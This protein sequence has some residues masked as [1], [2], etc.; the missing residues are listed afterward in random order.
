M[1]RFKTGLALIVA[2]TMLTACGTRYNGPSS[3]IL[4]ETEENTV[5]S[6][7]SNA[8]ANI[9]VEDDS[10]PPHEGMTRSLLTNEWVDDS[11]ADT[12]PIAVMIP[13]EKDAIP[14]YNLSKAS[15][16]YEANVEGRMTRLMA[17]YE[18]WAA[19]G[20]IGNVRSLRSYYAYWAF[21]W[22]AFLVH[23]GGPFFINE[24]IDQPTT[25]N[26][27]G[28][29][30]SDSAAFY[31]STDRK[32]PHNTYITGSKLLQVIQ[33]KGYSLSYRG[34]TDDH[35]FLF[36]TRSEPNTLTQ[37]GE[38]A[39][40]ATY[41]DMSG[42]YPLTRCYFDFN[43]K[44]GL[45]YRYQ[46]LV[47]DIDTP[48]IDAATGEQLAFKNILVQKIKSEDLGLSEGYLVF[49]CHDDTRDG[50]YFT[51]GMGIH[52]TWKKDSD[53]DATH[54]YDDNGNEILLNT[55]KTMICII[56]DNDNFTFR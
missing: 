42:C 18:D 36:A 8:P 15:I 24:L 16:L 5:S 56:I 39:S 27:D 1:K 30:A 55:G 29:S 52:V 12:R 11:V 10:V 19:L 6:T 28:M 7:P 32:A 13:N 14:Q 22:D 4:P 3:P 26:V 38:D 40:P 21:E 2:L 20:Q 9:V 54:Y 48:H 23:Y 33:Q 25:E 31:R 50:W 46:H 37:Y 51:N 49:Q 43:E 41:I 45:Y 35:H 53:Y 34:L 47:G 17:I 44:D